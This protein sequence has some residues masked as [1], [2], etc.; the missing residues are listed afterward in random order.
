M[1]ELLRLLTQLRPR[2]HP[3]GEA[4]FE[5]FA[6][7]CLGQSLG[8]LAGY[9]LTYALP[10]LPAPRAAKDM[11]LSAFQ[12]TLANNTLQ[13]AHL[14]KALQ[15]L[16][17]RKLVLFGALSMADTLYA[18]AGFRPLAEA[19]FLLA[20]ED[21]AGFCG[22]VRSLGYAEE[23][24]LR[25]A[26]CAL[27]DGCTTLGMFNHLPGIP[28]MP[29][30]LQ[31]FPKRVF[32]PSV[33][34]LGLEENVLALCARQYAEGYG[35]P[36]VEWVDLREALL[37]PEVEAPS[38]KAKAEA[39]GMAHALYASL[40]V[41]G[42]LFPNVEVRAFQPPVP[43]EWEALTNPWAKAFVE[44]PQALAQGRLALAQTQERQ[45]FAA[46]ACATPVAP[47]APAALA[48]PAMERK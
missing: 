38:L 47:T 19:S 25:H 4:P 41:L 21:V 37:H 2:F 35:G 29:K 12:E 23:V 13:L 46:M 16:E 22:Y 32:G 18:H 39:W 15:P 3:L 42:L 11:L 24:P 14:R 7:W 10:Q 36:W 48:L 40:A 44:L 27:S 8:A 9:N 28:H 34:A 45:A 1:L 5:V 30:A 17:G 6:P 31:A 43:A 33:F 20:E 26:V